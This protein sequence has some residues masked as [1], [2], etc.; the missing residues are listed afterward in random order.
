MCRIRQK[1]M[2]QVYGSGRCVDG[3]VVPLGHKARQIP[4]VI[5]MGVSKD[6]RIYRS[7]IDWG[8]IP[9]SQAQFFWSLK[10]SAI[11]EDSPVV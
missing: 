2:G 7:G 5:D 6:D 3:S 4:G 10:Q 8:R 1:D 9:V 11:D